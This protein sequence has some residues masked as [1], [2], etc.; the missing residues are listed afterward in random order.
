VTP[1]EPFFLT[2]QITDRWSMFGMP[3]VVPFR[4]R[5]ARLLGLAPR[6]VP[7]DAHA[8]GVLLF[9][10]DGEDAVIAAAAR[11]LTAGLY[12][13]ASF[14]MSRVVAPTKEAH[15]AD[16]SLPTIVWDDETI[17]SGWQEDEIDVV[18]S[19]F[20]A[21]VTDAGRGETMIGSLRAVASTE[22]GR[23]SKSLDAVISM[24]D[25]IRPETLIAGM[26]AIASMHPGR[27][28]HDDIV[29]PHAVA[30]SAA[31]PWLPAMIGC[32][33]GHR[34]DR[35]DR[36][37]IMTPESSRVCTDLPPAMPPCLVARVERHLDDGEDMT[38][39]HLSPLRGCVPLDELGVDPVEPINPMETLRAMNALNREFTT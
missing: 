38:M 1:R 18:R 7:R 6:P 8:E 17:A 25:P 37:W 14:Y 23:V 27:E 9:E 10:F 24:R 32:A 4:T 15:A 34:D 11:G 2:S 5:V 28:R 33:W 30:C 19:L 22:E 21:R 26:R 13:R 12:R 20:A 29:P 39:I 3:P 35:W 31:T 16:P 36:R